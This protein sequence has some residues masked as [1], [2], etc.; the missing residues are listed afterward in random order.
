[1]EN[2]RFTLFNGI[3]LFIMAATAGIAAIRIAGRN[4]SRWPLAYYPV[5]LGYALGFKY[6]LNP[7]WVAAG[8]ALTLMVRAGV[9]P[10][11]ARIAEYAVLAYV[12]WRALG[13]LLLW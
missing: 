12:F 7:G 2:F 8:A 5:L 13:L 3:T 4:R 11:A 6:S 10:L 9:Q 1:M